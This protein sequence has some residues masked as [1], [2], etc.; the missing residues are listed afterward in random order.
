[1]TRIGSFADSPAGSV[2]NIRSSRSDSQVVGNLNTARD[3]SSNG[4]R[5]LFVTVKSPRTVCP[6][7]TRS[8]H[9][10]EMETL[11]HRKTDPQADATITSTASV[12]GI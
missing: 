10:P 3:T 11:N 9:S 12:T 2:G 8:G 4:Q 7:V 6:A 5:L 1:M